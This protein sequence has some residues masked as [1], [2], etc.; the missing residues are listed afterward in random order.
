MRIGRGYGGTAPLLIDVFLLVLL[1]W[2][3][4]G[5]GIGV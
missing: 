5:R 2:I 3:W 4:R 1:A